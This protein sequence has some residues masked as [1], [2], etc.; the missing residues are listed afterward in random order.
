[1]RTVCVNFATTVL[2]I[3]VSGMFNSFFLFFKIHIASAAEQV[4]FAILV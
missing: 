4:F 1:M 2:S 3:L